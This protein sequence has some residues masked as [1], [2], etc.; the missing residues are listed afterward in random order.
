MTKKQSIA[1]TVNDLSQEIRRLEATIVEDRSAFARLSIAGVRAATQAERDQAKEDAAACNGRVQDSRMLIEGLKIALE[2]AQAQLT[3]D[4]KQRARAHL[5]DALQRGLADLQARDVAAERAQD[6]L[7]QAGEAVAEVI[8]LGRQAFGTFRQFLTDD[9]GYAFDPDDNIIA[10]SVLGALMRAGALTP[11]TVEHASSLAF[12]SLTR[13]QPLTMT[14]GEQG[15]RMTSHIPVQ[16]L[17]LLPA[18]AIPKPAASARATR[19]P[20]IEVKQ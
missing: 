7:Q 11:D 2:E 12:G 18:A 8:A 4:R 9:L 13:F 20:G 5:T 1:E 14:V 19:R 17:R 6:L 3:E 15:A 10:C 16:A